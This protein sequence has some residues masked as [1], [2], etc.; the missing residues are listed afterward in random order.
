MYH[1]MTTEFVAVTAGPY[2]NT[3]VHPLND[4]RCHAGYRH[5][6]RGDGR[7]LLCAV[8]WKELTEP[9]Q[10]SSSGGCGAVDVGPR[11]QQRC[12]HA[13]DGHRAAAVWKEVWR[14]EKKEQWMSGT[15]GANTS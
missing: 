10:H 2:R 11:V 7:G 5:E 1:S 4:S 12:A 15:R 8:K 13:A 3:C 9:R 6:R 14:R